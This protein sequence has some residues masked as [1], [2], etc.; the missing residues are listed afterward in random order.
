M[1][2]SLKLGMVVVV[3]VDG[4]VSCRNFHRRAFAVRNPWPL[5]L[6]KIYRRIP[7]ERRRLT[8]A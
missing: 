7:L 2:S 5:W 1:C 8:R 4:V 3:F 6:P